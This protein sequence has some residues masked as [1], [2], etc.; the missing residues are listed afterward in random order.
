MKIRKENPHNLPH[1]L[2]ERQ[3]KKNITWWSKNKDGTT[4]VIRSIPSAT[5]EFQVNQARELVIRSFARQNRNVRQ[6]L[7]TSTDVDRWI[8][9]I[10]VVHKGANKLRGILPS[11]AREIFLSG[12]RRAKSRSI[13]WSLTQGE[14]SVIVKRSNGFCEVSGMPLTLS[15][16]MK[17]GPYGPSIDRID[18]SLGYTKENIRL[19]CIAMNYAMNEWGFEA[20]LPIAISIAERHLQES[21]IPKSSSLEYESRKKPDVQTSG[22]LEH[23]DLQG[24]YWRSGRDSNPRPPA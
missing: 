8:S 11:W 13:K 19:V 6:S 10:G 22:F 17:K 15:I 12:A 23:L 21:H 9:E 2:Y 4:S 3:S 16:G 14:F 7:A 5:P 20:F 24:F 18:S 1:R